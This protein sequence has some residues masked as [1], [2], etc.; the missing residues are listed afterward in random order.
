MTRKRKKRRAR[1]REAKRSGRSRERQDPRVQVPGANAEGTG[2][3][4]SVATTDGAVDALVDLA[5][6]SWRLVRLFNRVLRKLDAGEGSRY[7]SKVE[8]FLRRLEESLEK[9][10]L[11]LVDLTGREYEP[12]FP[13]SALNAE[14][15]EDGDRLVVD[16]MLE[17]IVMGPEG[18]V[19]RPGTVMLRK[20]EQ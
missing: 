6:E 19:R 1:K 5:V 10:D 20:V 9:A 18:V 17:P 13:A 12:G 2:S 7:V 3:P 15:F 8:W 16:V 4:G 11:R 14:D